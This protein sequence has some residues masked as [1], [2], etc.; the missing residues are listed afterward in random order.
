MGRLT[1]DTEQGPRERNVG[2]KTEGKGDGGHSK[3]NDGQVLKMP[4]I[5]LISGFGQ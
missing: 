4:T 2:E 1:L 3:S 5:R